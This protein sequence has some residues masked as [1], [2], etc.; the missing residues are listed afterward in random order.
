MTE[1]V[2]N[3]MGQKAALGGILM[4]GARFITRLID[5]TMM[6]GLARILV[7]KDFGLVAIA[8]SLVLVTEAILELPLN[9]ALLRL[10]AITKHHYDTAFTLSLLRGLVLWGIL[11]GG[12]WPF[13]YFYHDSRLIALV[14]VLSLGPVARSLTSPRLV[15]YQKQ[16]S[17]WRDFAVELFGKVAGFTFGVSVAVATHSY[18]AIAVS[19]V[20]YPI[21]MAIGSYRLAPYRPRLALSELGVFSGF[22]G[23]MSVAQAIGALNWQFER[24]LLGK[25]KVMSQLGLFSTASDVANI[26]FLA[27]FGPLLRPMLAAFAFL[28]EDAE[29]LARAYQTA[30]CAIIAVGLPFLVG[31][32]IVADATVRVILGPKWHEAAPWVQWLALSLTPA[33]F[34][35]ASGPLFLSLGKPIT[36]VKRNAVEFSVKL[37]IAVVGALLWGFY[38]II[39]ARFLS[40]LTANLFCTLTVRRMIGLSLRDQLLA[41]WRSVV[42]TAVMAAIVL[43]LRYYLGPVPEIQDALLQI[44]LI[45]MTGATSYC[46]VL[47]ALWRM[48][49]RPDGVEQI[50][51]NMLGAFTGK[52]QA[53]TFRLALK[54]PKELA[55]ANPER[56]I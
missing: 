10:P 51:I 34:G 36:L 26:P 32:S 25:L 4:V 53:A 2:P 20:A 11:I 35:L 48:A 56:L 1:P 33:L 52:L 46:F 54:G 14:C 17:F 23:W 22:V 3:K 47:W 5:M 15:E 7:P 18:W 41:P 28:R 45:G 19:I 50:A 44:T 6:I 38:G 39:V 30:C 13:A 27:L 16:L 9:Q 31:E 55:A 8:M 37:P 49:G 40:E 24:L 43:P 12:A 21:G 42:S 29:R